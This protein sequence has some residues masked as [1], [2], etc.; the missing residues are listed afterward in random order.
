VRELV[1]HEL[2]A[3][4]RP[5]ELL[6]TERV[7]DR[8]LVGDGVP[9]RSPGHRL[10]RLGQHPVGVFERP[11][12]GEARIGDEGAHIA[13]V[14]PAAPRDEPGRRDHPSGSRQGWEGRRNGMERV[15]TP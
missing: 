8:G 6:A 12:G 7:G 10:A 13:V 4:E 15:G 3:G 14:R 2:E 1:L 11:S 9:E 5:A